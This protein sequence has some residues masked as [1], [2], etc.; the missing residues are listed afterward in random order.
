MNLIRDLEEQLTELHRTPNIELEQHFCVD[1][2]VIKTVINEA[3]LTKSDV[4]LEIGAGTG[5]LT[6]ELVKHV[7]KVIA[8]EADSAL[9]PILRPLSGQVELIFDNALNV[10]KTRQD[11][12]KIVANIP[13]QISEP[14][15][16]Y[17][18]L[19]KHVQWSVL[20]VSRSF[21]LKA[22]QHPVLSA[23]LD[24]ELVLDIPQDA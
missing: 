22:Q 2:N 17:L 23:F 10:L 14:L 24:I 6:K 8:V 5:I 3:K 15:L 4:V 7:Q 16:K 21:A 11:F 18:C 1:F 12:T 13:Y 20:T 19:A 9:E